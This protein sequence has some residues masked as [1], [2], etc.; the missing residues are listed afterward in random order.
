MN[1]ESER[2]MSGQ[3]GVYEIEVTPEMIEAGVDELR[4]HHYACDTSYMVEC[5]F[6]AMSYASRSAS[7]TKSPR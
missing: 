7:A 2:H 3:A 6:R 4:D 5:I 1:T